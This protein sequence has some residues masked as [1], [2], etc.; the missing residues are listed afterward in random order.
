MDSES[1]DSIHGLTDFGI[2]HN[3]FIQSMDSRWNRYFRVIKIEVY[4]Q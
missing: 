3:T 4:I 2:E 1:M